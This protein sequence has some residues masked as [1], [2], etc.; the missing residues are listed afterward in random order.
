MTR[1]YNVA[2]AM[3][4]TRTEGVL[5]P[6]LLNRLEQLCTILAPNPLRSFSQGSGPDVLRQ[7]EILITGWGCP[8]IG[9]DILEL[10]PKLKLIAHAAGTVKGF[11]SPDVLDAGI[12]VTHA[13]EA[14]AVPV[15]E[16]TLAAIIFANK[17]VFRLRDIYCSDRNRNRT[18]PLT[19][20][21]VGNFKRTIGIVGASRI[22]RRVIDLLEPFDFRIVL[23][24]P[25]V[26]AREAAALGAESV[27][28]DGLMR[29]SDVVS[30]HA[31]A[32]PST[33]GMIDRRHLALMRDGATLINTAR[34][35]IVNQD[36]LIDELRTGRI[37]AI[38]DVTYPEVPEASSALYDLPNVF[39]TPHIAGAIGNERERLG[40]FIVEEI[41][42]FV[43]GLPLRSA[44]TA[45]ALE[46]MA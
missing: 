24:D 4:P 34:G 22:G 9:R 35:I 13:A 27:S 43:R 21:P 1:P 26:S 7:A 33:Q 29:L 17:Q 45:S 36:D 44:I 25:Y 42:R 12:T 20:Q 18:F 28:L 5:T 30:I 3:D 8:A 46:T 16:F 40:E 31:P 2:L 15:A 39:L 41:E 19:S 23:H 37:D 38:I 11:L 6:E 10:A 14:N 32:L